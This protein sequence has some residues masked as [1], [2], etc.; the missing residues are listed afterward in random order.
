PGARATTDCPGEGTSLCHWR[1]RSP[2]SSPSKDSRTTTR[3]GDS[4][5]PVVTRLHQRHDQPCPRNR[6]HGSADRA[7]VAGDIP[8]DLEHGAAA[9][10]AV[11]VSQSAVSSGLP[12]AHR[13]V[14][15]R[16]T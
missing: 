5:L 16:T 15:R 4:E 2:R 12:L 9:L 7:V 1:G 3:A 11:A 14:N 8:G 6:V 13:V 10:A